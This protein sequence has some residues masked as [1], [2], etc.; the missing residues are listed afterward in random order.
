MAAS[1]PFEVTPV[2]ATFGAVVTGLKLTEL[3]EEAMAALYA[4]WLDHA[5]LIFPG[6]HLDDDQQ[7]AF[8]RRLGE[9]E[10][11]LLRIGNLDEAGQVR[12][13]DDD[14]MRTFAGNVA[15][16]CDSTFKEV[17]A[18]GAVFT[19]RIV[20]PEGGETGW[21]DMR[22]A[23]DAL[24]KAEQARLEGLTCHHSLGYSQGRIGKLPSKRGVFG[25]IYLDE[26][27]LRPL[28][29]VHPETGRRSLNIGRHACGVPGMTP[30][31]SERF[32]DDLLAFACQPPR[33]WH[34]RWTPGDA[35]IWDNRCLVHRVL[36]WDV[37]QPRDMRHTRLA[38][39]ESE[40]ALAA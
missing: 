11:E 32:L 3:D 9:L 14:V 10:I 6:Q 35:V 24:P 5:L 38:G 30:E 36:P 17:Q 37:T 39:G 7:L 23:F 16:H 18:K 4:A 28:V 34:H 15:W 29:K 2:D 31:A 27:P 12:P 1:T 33:T 13:P 40:R 21:A 19:A 22:A 20:P 25:S 8:A 26:S